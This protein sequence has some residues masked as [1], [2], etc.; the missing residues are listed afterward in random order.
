MTERFGKLVSF[1]FFEPTIFVKLLNPPGSSSTFPVST[2]HVR[3]AGPSVGAA[4]RE[5]C[6]T[7][8]GVPMPSKRLR[9]GRGGWLGEVG[10]ELII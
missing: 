7:G 3:P 6:A 1:L 9:V 4:G 5:L 8:A 2:S 10:L